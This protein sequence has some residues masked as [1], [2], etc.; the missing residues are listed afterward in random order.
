V[1]SR[2]D[3]E[4]VVFEQWR[5]ADTSEEPLLHATLEAD[6]SSFGGGKLD[7]DLDPSDT[8]PRNDNTKKKIDNRPHLKV[9]TH[10]IVII[11]VNQ[12][13]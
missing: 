2:Y 3:S 5:A 6:N 8:H 9:C 7:V 4:G 12:K 10:K 11:I 13:S 1:H